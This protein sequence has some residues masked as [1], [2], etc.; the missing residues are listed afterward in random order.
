M[1]QEITDIIV[2]PVNDNPTQG[3]LT[4]GDKSYPCALGKKG[5]GLLKTEGDLKTPAGSFPLR[6]VYYR[7]DKLSRPIYTQVPMMALLK[8]DG[9]CDDPDDLAYNQ[10]VMLPYHTSAENLWRDDDAY[11]VIVVL[12]HN[13]NPIKKGGGSAIFLHVAREA[14]NDT[15]EGTAGCIALK[16]QD[17]LEILPQLS[18]MTILKVTAP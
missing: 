3:I 9:W 12:G 5:I 18:P 1:G 17:I 2:R 10:S 6:T 8:E 14:S 7:Y 11:D 15:F 4:L 16:K 13:D